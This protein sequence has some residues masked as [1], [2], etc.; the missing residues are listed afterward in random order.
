MKR[1]HNGRLRTH[2]NW[3]TSFGSVFYVFYEQYL[4]MWRD[5]ITSLL[6]SL[7]T[8]FGVSFIL[9]G[10][11]LISAVVIVFMVTLILINMLGMMWLWNISLNAISLV[12]LVV[13]RIRL[14]SFEY[15]FRLSMPFHSYTEFGYRRGIH[16]AHCTSLFHRKGNK[17]RAS[18]SG[19]IENGLQ[20]FVWHHIDEILWHFGS[21]IVHITS[22]SEPFLIFE[23]EI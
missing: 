1:S 16:I 15:R 18:Q 3:L 17:W 19:S 8:I 10:F 6:L 13:V 4:T 7:V 9:T 2:F 22:E 14:D 21:S 20:C 12:N 5:T 11:D 23:I